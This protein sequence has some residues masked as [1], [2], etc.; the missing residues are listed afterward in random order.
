M[1]GTIA[2][3]SS[4]KAHKTYLRM[5][6]NVQL[7]TSVPK[8]PQIDNPVIEFLKKDALRLHHPYDDAFVV[9]MRVEDYNMH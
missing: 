3:G 8:M 1:G 4:K 2:A 7:T 5:T 9:S 6:H